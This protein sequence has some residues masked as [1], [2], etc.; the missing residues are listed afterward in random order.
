MIAR[1]VGAIAGVLV[2]AASAV[3]A[4]QQVFRAGVD[5]VIVDVAVTR[6][7]RPVDGLTAT[8][9]VLTD[10]GVPQQILDVS[11]ESVPIDLTLIA[12]MSGGGLQ[13]G[14]V[15]RGVNRVREQLRPGDRVRILTFRATLQEVVAMTDPQSL[16]PFRGQA[17]KMEAFGPSAPTACYDA[18]ALSIATPPAVGRR[19]VAILFS[20][21][22]DTVSFIDKAT[23]LDVVRRSSTALFVVAVV[24]D[25]NPRERPESGATSRPVPTDPLAIP[26]SF[27]EEIAGMTGGTVQT[28]QPFSILR[29]EP[30]RFAASL[31]DPGIAAAFLN[32]LDAFRTSYLLRYEPRG[33]ERSGW[34]DLSV[35]VTGSGDDYHVRARKGYHR[36]DGK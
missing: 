26:P 23:A 12:D 9:F 19:Q 22:R 1:R 20:S 4:R 3:I 15:V 29:N 28:I 36:P 34:H 18:V 8:D 31:G 32:A 17:G 14:A 30:G 27:F 25:L 24:G 16:A 5:V 11:R 10:N 21:G 35:S 2:T 13:Q 6:N 7:N 33:V